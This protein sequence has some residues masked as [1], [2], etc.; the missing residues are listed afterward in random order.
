MNKNLLEQIEESHQE[1]LVYITKTLLN[2]E[3][4][5]LQ[6]FVEFMLTNEINPYSFLPEYF[7]GKIT[8]SEGFASLLQ[9]LHH[10]LYDDGFV[11]F[12]VVNKQPYLTFSNEG[13]DE[14]IQ[15]IYEFLDRVQWYH[16]Y[17]LKK[18]FLFDVRKRGVD[19]LVAIE[20]YKTYAA[21]DPAWLDEVA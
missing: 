18:C 4:P 11:K 10:A 12:I 7:A 1:S 20:H 15:D 3:E 17:H 9:E 2:D 19:R 21:F 14:S 13:S 6:A 16:R 5:E 8:S